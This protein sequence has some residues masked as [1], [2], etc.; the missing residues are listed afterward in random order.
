MKKRG[1]IGEGGDLVEREREIKTFGVLETPPSN[2]CALSPVGFISV[3]LCVCWCSPSVAAWV[4]WEAS[5]V[6]VLD[7]PPSRRGVCSNHM[8]LLQHRPGG[9]YSN[10]FDHSHPKMVDEVRS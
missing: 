8:A 4:F 2:I 6:H 1:G 10:G 3:G 9:W 7:Y 5:W